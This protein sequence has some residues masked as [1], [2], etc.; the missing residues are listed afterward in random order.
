MDPEHND[1][2]SPFTLK[3]LTFEFKYSERTSSSE[4]LFGETFTIHNLHSILYSVNTQQTSNFL[5]SFSQILLFKRGTSH[6]QVW[7][8]FQLEETVHYVPA[9]YTPD[10]ENVPVNLYPKYNPGYQIVNYPEYQTVYQPEYYP[11]YQPVYYPEYNPVYQPDYYPKYNPVYQPV[12]QPEYYPKYNPVYQPE[13]YP[14]YN[15]V[16]Q[17]V[18]YPEYY[19]DYST[20]YYQFLPPNFY[21][22]PLTVETFEEDCFLPTPQPPHNHHPILPE[23]KRTM[24]KNQDPNDGGQDIMVN[25]LLG[26]T[27]TYPPENVF[28]SENVSVP[29]H[30]S[31]PESASLLKNVS[32]PEPASPPEHVST[33]TCISP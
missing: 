2:S 13:Y 27:A 12:Y 16:Y 21:S 15:P 26:G 33:Q 25:G 5:H 4:R 8:M 18:Y 22:Q 17:P 7:K 11:L 1:S 24:I 32:P 29:K 9:I 14:K 23:R 31:P 30:V 10:L 19:A 20:E 6:H 28:P 3:L